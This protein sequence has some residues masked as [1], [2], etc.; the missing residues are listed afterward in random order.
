MLSCDC[1]DL[2]WGGGKLFCVDVFVCV[3]V[4]V[5]VCFYS[6]STVYDSGKA[7]L[8]TVTASMYTRKFFKRVL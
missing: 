2:L 7:I 8:M 3:R 6:V 5:C 1:N 4:C